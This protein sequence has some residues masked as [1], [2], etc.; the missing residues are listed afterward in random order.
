MVARDDKAEL[1]AGR[2]LD[3]GHVLALR[4]YYE[5]TDVGGF[6]YYANYFKFIERGRTDFLRLAGIDHSTLWHVHKLALAV[7]SCAIEYHAPARLDDRIEIYTY[8]TAMRGASMEAEQVVRREA[9]ELARSKVRI[10]C[11]DAS[12]RAA[13][14]PPTIRDQLKHFVKQ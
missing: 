14:L 9:M 7:K 3:D 4:I 5:D 11:I 2:L 10:A 1:S 8:L 13:R 6:V 12:G